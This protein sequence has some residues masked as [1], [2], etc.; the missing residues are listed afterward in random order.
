MKGSSI[1]NLG[2]VARK[3]TIRKKKRARKD[4]SPYGDIANMSSSNEWKSITHKG[5][6]K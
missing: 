3:D 1:K 2:E 5:D 6:P 4:V